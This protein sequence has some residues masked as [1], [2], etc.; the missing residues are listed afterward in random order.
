M[1]SGEF[2]AKVAGLIKSDECES[3]K[4]SGKTPNPECDQHEESFAHMY[5]GS[6]SRGELDELIDEARKIV[7]ESVDTPLAVK[8]REYSRG[9]DDDD[10]TTD[11]RNPV[12]L[13][14]EEGGAWVS[15]QHYYRLSDIGQVCGECGEPTD[16]IDLIDGEVVCAN[17]RTEAAKELEMNDAM[18]AE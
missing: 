16:L 11:D 2:V 12:E 5:D 1:T 4:K 15:V 6:N 8:F 18:Q 13:C 9:F 17:C 10:R 3:C 7:E 14:E